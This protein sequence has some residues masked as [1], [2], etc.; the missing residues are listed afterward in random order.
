MDFL[1]FGFCLK[2][3][4][5]QILFIFNTF[6]TIIIEKVLKTVIIDPEEEW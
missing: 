3:R 2:R 6:Q 1:D 5:T 4:K